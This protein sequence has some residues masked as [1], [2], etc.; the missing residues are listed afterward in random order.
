MQNIKNCVFLYL[1]PRQKSQLLGTL[2]SYYKKFLNLSKDELIAKF[3]DDEKYYIEIENPHFEFVSEYF[4]DD[5]FYSDLEKYFSYLEYEKKAREKLEPYLEK[6]KEL[7]KIQRKKAAEFKMSKLKP[8]K[9]Q[10]AYYE[11]LVC[12]HKVEKK[13]VKDASRLDLR[14]WIMEILDKN[15]YDDNKES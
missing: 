2:K 15:E 9:K 8:T 14:N 13:E 5:R 6:Q 4:N 11:K 1:T 12:A 3:L 7:A 10:L